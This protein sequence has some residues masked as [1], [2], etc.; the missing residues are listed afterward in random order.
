MPDLA[1]IRHC[2]EITF[3]S[4]PALAT[5]HVDGWIARFAHGVTGRSNSLN[6]LCPG[7][8]PLEDILGYVA[9][10][11]AARQLPMNLRLTPLCP[12]G[13]REAVIAKGWRIEKESHVL[14]APL[15]GS[16]EVDGRVAI[17]PASSEHWRRQY[18]KANPRFDP[19]RLG[20][21]AAIHAAI[22]PKTGFAILE[23]EGEVLA[24]GLAVVEGAAVS[25]HEIA[26]MG[27]VRGRGIGRRLVGSLL[28]WAFQEGA[29]QA[30]LQVQG[31][32]EP[33]IKLYKSLG[34]AHV[35]DY[36]YAVAP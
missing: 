32:N 3:N 33:A 15:S 36:A 30:I 20:T 27:N 23:E 19:Q 10:F 1:F 35:Y 18:I 11:Y 4:W 6:A 28:A 21:I 31:D 7:R 29:T 9:P 17:S 16:L 14:C 26:T 5:L 8:R 22:L 13:T 2:E 12:Q 24:L 34:F 25:L